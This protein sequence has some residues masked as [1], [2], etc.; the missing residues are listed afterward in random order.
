MLCFMLAAVLLLCGCTAGNPFTGG[1]IEELLRAPQP[2]QQL[3]AVQKAM[4]S[5]L[6]ESMQLKYP[7]GGGEMSPILFADLDGDGADEAVAL[8]M[9]ESKGQNVHLAVMENIDAGWEVVYELEGLSTEVAS[10]QLA[11]L[12]T[13]GTQLIVG[14]ANATLTDK[15]LTV[16]DYHSDT[17]TRLFE[18]AYVYYLTADID[19]NAQSDL[20]V[21]ASGVEA[22][23]MTLQW[24]AEQTG[25][26]TTVQTLALDERF[27]SCQQLYAVDS[28]GVYG[29]IAEGTF[30]SGWAADEVFRLQPEGKFARWPQSDVDVP[31][32]SLR[33]LTGLTASVLNTGGVLRVPTNITAVTTLSYSRRFYFVT[34]RDY[35]GEREAPVQPL[36]AE[37][38]SVPSAVSSASQA[39]TASSVPSAASSASQT[40]TASSVPSAASSASQ[41]GTASSVPPPDSN[42]AAQPFF[43]VYDSLYGYFVRLP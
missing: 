4:N 8:Y 5:Y 36:Q 1:T 32:T 21:A 27:V 38:Q 10:V 39:G 16:Y 17:V 13:G 14:Y 34:W 6:G 22:G 33:S 20:V 9:A 11:N 2:T 42:A 29:L 40:V 12:V 23:A 28:D 18:Q 25:M 30:A 24:L 35:L 26:L 31:Q 41:A 37:S 15:Y 3:S 19:H 7:R 43:G